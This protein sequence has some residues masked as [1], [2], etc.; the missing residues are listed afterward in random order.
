[1]R[2]AAPCTHLIKLDAFLPPEKRVH[3][4]LVML[5]RGRVTQAP[6]THLRDGDV[7]EEMEGA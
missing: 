7:S 6:H 1:M 2:R 5:G 3:V 4:K